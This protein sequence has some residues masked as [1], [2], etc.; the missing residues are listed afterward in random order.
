M[1]TTTVKP[2]AANVTAAKP[3]ITGCVSTAPVG[4]TLPTTAAAELDA[5][6]KR[7]GYL[8]EDGLTNS[9]GISTEQI[10]AWGGDVVL[11]TQTER[12]D[13]WGFGLM[14]VLN[15]DVLKAT[16]G[17][18]NVSGDLATGITVKSN[19]L[20]MGPHSYVFDTI[21]NGNVL[22][23]VVI[24]NGT[25]SELEDISYKSDEAVVYNQ[26]IIATPDGD[27][28]THYEYISKKAAS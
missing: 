5:A 24:P 1:S 17:D 21:L 27:G 3:A 12:T 8:T 6:F 11:N 16:F 18:D 2:S 14:E 13:R 20:E 26:T 22:K 15:P 23:R 19:G 10:K 4:T 25:L 9:L 7:L 28:N